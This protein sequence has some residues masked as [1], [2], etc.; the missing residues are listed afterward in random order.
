MPR[1]PNRVRCVVPSCGNWAM[2][3]CTRCRAHLHHVLGPGA[4]GHPRGNL[5]AVRHARYS[6]RLSPVALEAT[7]RDLIARTSLERGMLFLR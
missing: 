5:S 4:T 1:N 3:G 7:V 2:R 6:F